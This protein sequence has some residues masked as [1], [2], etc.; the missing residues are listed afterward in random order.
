MTSVYIGHILV[1]IS[2]HSHFVGTFKNC[3]SEVALNE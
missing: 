3:L 1:A 2:A